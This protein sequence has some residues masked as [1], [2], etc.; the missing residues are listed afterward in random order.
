MPT[1]IKPVILV[2]NNL[3][4]SGNGQYIDPTS[5]A[6]GMASSLTFL[7]G[8]NVWAAVSGVN[9]AGDTMTG[10]LVLS[11]NP[12]AALGAA[13]KQYVDTSVSASVNKSGDTMTGLLVLSAN[14]SAALG[15][16]TKQ[17]VDTLVSGLVWDAP[18]FVNDVI[19]DTLST[20][21]GS[22]VTGQSFIVGTSPSAAWTG[23]AGR[24]VEWNGSA[25]IDVLG[26]ALTV[27]DRFGINLEYGGTPAGGLTGKSLNIA[28][29]SGGSA[30]SFTYT[31]TG[32]TLYKT[33]FVNT[34]TALDFGDT[35][36]FNGT[37]WVQINRALTSLASPAFSGTP[38]A[39]TAAAGTNTTQLATTA[40][41]NAVA[42][43]TTINAQTGTTYTFAMTDATYD[44]HPGAL[45]TFNN[46]AAVAVTIPLN[47]SVAFPNGSRIEGVQKGAGKVTIVPTSGVTINSV[48]SYKSV[49]AQFGAF[50]LIKESA[51]VWY[52][53]GSLIA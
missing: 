23:L 42:V 52:L 8:D 12:S 16:A 48:S 32:P 19:H 17:Y 15:A 37:A 5:M 39:P 21:P 26:R 40:F 36:T 14:P 20:P 4:E 49:S 25:W 44:A 2:S 30:G 3:V 46:A 33:V 47:A 13:T 43:S 41:V 38:T 11:A 24:C 9:V 1:L 6:A 10:P 51:D 7:R 50:S 27:G 28:Q 53:I 29:V 34:P 22:P 31:F 35:Y 18:V 45:V